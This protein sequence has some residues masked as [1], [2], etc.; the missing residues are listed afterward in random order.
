MQS[1]L[2]LL[3]LQSCLAISTGRKSHVTSAFRNPA[4]METVSPEFAHKS[5]K[6]IIMDEHV[7]MS[8]NFTRLKD[9]EYENHMD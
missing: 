3:L 7:I 6:V 5:V 4:Q 8:E 2:R 9:T 1:F